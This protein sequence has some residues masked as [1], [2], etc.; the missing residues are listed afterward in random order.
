MLTE[1][2]RKTLGRRAS[3]DR[4]LCL[5]IFPASTRAT[6]DPAIPTEAGPDYTWRKCI[7]PLPTVPLTLTHIAPQSL[8]PQHIG[9]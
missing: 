1:M 7:L 2:G 4:T 6:P 8:K 9:T 5:P 3:L